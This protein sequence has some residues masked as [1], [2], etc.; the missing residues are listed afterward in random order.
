MPL[1]HAQPSEVAAW[2]AALTIALE[3]LSELYSVRI[4]HAKIDAI[5]QHTWHRKEFKG[6]AEEYLLSLLEG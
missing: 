1:C 4:S 6:A 2:E 5:V 3:E